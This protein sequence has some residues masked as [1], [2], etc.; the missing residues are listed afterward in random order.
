MT[1]TRERIVEIA[2]KLFMQKSFKEVTIKEI[3]EKTGVSQGAFFHY[4]KTKEDLFLE[5][6]GNVLSSA[7][8]YYDSLTKD[9]LQQFYSQYIHTFLGNFLP[10]FISTED[11]DS[12]M[13]YFALYFEAIKIFP[14]FKHKIADIHEIEFNNWKSVVSKARANGEISTVMKDEE[15]AKMFIN[16]GD[17]LAL[18]S[19]YMGYSKEDATNKWIALWDSFY[20]VLKSKN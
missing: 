7:D 6:I 5:I 17:G 1:D 10:E 12:G 2:V 15:I 3:V 8:G 20:E 11:G 18:H 13:N 14:D 9:S 19:I 4:F 16:S